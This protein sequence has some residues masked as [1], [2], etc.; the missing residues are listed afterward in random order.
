MA[1]E[2][3]YNELITQFPQNAEAVS[4]HDTNRFNEPSTVFVGGTGTVRVEAAGNAGDVTFTVSAGNP[5]PVLCRRVYST[6][7]TA[8]GLVRIW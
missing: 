2:R 6:G 7:T 1:G 5:V 8:T 3:H 4:P